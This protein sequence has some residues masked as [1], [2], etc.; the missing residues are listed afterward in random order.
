VCEVGL[1]AKARHINYGGYVLWRTG[2][3]LAAGGW[4]PALGIAA[5]N[6]YHFVYSSIPLMDKY[7]VKRYPSQWTKYKH[8]VKWLLIPGLF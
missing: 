3:A 6:L 2:F 4:V 5:F 7:M 1:W 8:D